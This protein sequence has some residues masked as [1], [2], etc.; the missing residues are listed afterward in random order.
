MTVS[1]L[2]ELQY[3]YGVNLKLIVSNLSIEEVTEVTC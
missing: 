2:K 3:G 1:I